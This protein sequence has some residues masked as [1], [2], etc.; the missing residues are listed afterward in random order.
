MLCPWRALARIAWWARS[1]KRLR[2]GSDVSGSWVA[3]WAERSASSFAS[4]AR[5][6][7]SRDA[8]AT[9]RKRTA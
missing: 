8:L 5:R 6:R 2:L 3:S 1:R 9:S 7:S 4:S